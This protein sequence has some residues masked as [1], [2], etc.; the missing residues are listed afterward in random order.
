MLVRASDDIG[1]RAAQFVRRNSHLFTGVTGR[2]MKR[3][4]GTTDVP[5]NESDLLSYMLFDGRF[6]RELIALGRADA[7]ARHDELCDF[8]SNL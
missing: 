6:A 7:Q 2:L 5:H 8:F 1:V 4:A 3:L